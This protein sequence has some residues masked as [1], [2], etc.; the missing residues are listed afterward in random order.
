MVMKIKYFILVSI[1]FMILFGN[2]SADTKEVRI[3]TL[4]DYPPACFA[5]NTAVTV[6]VE[7]LTP[8][9]DSAIL[10]GR[11]WEVVREA[12]H[13]QGF[14]IILHTVPIARALHYVTSGTVDVIFPFV[15]TDERLKT[16]SF[17]KEPVVYDSILLYHPHQS[18]NK[19]LTLSSF[20]GRKIAVI[21]KWAYGKVWEKETTIQRIEADSIMQCFNLLDGKWVDGVIGYETAFDYTLKT[22]GF[23]KKYRKTAPIDKVTNYMMGLKDKENK[24]FLDAYDKGLRTI[25]QNGVYEK[26]LQKWR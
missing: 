3:A 8:G 10:Q 22:L 6:G 18:A 13:S 2:V 5:K 20:K 1:F 14:T 24:F 25:K 21:R 26:I 4:T 12:Y 17:S 11:S 7:R 9:Q 15:I 23:E 16:F 19:M